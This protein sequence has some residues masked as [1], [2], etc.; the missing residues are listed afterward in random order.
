LAAATPW[1]CLSPEAGSAADGNAGAPRNIAAALGRIFAFVAFYVVCA[2]AAGYFGAP[3]LVKVMGGWADGRM[4]TDMYV[5]LIAALAAT[6]IMVRSID[7]RA[8]SD[9]GLG[10]AAA[11]W[12]PLVSGMLVG[13]VAIGFTC[14][15]LAA[16]GLLRFSAAPANASWLGAALRVTWVLAPAALAEE[17]LF[18]GYLLT[19]AREAVGLRA[20]VVLMSALFGLVHLM[21]PDA[22]PISVMIVMLSG[23]LLS[24]VRFR[25]QSLYAAFAAH[26]AWNWLMA[27]PLHAPVSGLRVESPGYIATTTGPAWISGGTWGPEGGLVAALGML[28]GLWYF[29]YTY[30]RHRREES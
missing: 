27:V 16:A 23:V 12:R 2:T 10:R 3:V 9:V 20:A 26:L 29:H 4:G 17:L 22:T 28:G 25:L 18:R 21:N 1:H 11:Q 19:V 13:L 30:T 6:A 5:E 14:A 15:V 7:R 24:T 8:W